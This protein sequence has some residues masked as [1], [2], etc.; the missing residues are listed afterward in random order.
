MYEFGRGIGPGVLFHPCHIVLTAAQ[1][2][3]LQGWF[4]AK[5]FGAGE[6]HSTL[7]VGFLGSVIIS[8]NALAV[9]FIK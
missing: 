3:R 8:A 5:F 6:A 9:P 7:S 1:G 4:C 2:F